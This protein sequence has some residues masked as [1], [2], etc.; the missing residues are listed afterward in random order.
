[1]W[2]KNAQW[3]QMK[4]KQILILKSKIKDW[5]IHFFLIKMHVPDKFKRQS[6][7]YSFTLLVQGTTCLSLPEPNGYFLHID[8]TLTPKQI[9]IFLFWRL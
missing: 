7:Q 3:D 4:S 6:Y 2:E 8:R 1:M 5:M 9:N